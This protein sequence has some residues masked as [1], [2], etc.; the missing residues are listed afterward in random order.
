MHSTNLLKDIVLLIL[1][2]VYIVNKH[3]PLVCLRCVVHMFVFNK[4]L[5]SRNN[6][7]SKKAKK[8]RFKNQTVLKTV[9][10]KINYLKLYALN[11]A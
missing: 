2:L 7:L 3:Y 9:F 6:Q 11:P 1:S 4:M 10:K 8:D 5:L